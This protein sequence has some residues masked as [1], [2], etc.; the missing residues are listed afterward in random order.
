MNHMGKNDALKDR[1]NNDLDIFLVPLLIILSIIFILIPPFNQ[2]FLRVMLALPLLLF[3]PGYM[4]LA[5]MFPKR[6]ELSALQRFTLSIGLS[7]A[8]TVFDGFGLNYTQWGFRPNSIT[9]SLSIIIG[10]LLWITFRQRRK[11]GKESY[12]FSL[13]DIGSFIKIL[14]TRE[15]E[16]G[17]EY[18]PALEKVL[19]KTM[20]IAILIV[21]A[22]VIYA[23]W[24]YEPQKFTSLY[25]LGQNGK[26]ENYLSDIRVGEPATILV[27]VEN[28]EY[29][30]INYTLLVKLGGITLTKE[31]IHLKH[32]DKWLNNVTF[33]PQMTSTI[34]FAGANRS[35]LEFQLL[36][37]DVPY[38]SVHL[39]VNTSLDL[40]TFAQLP[41]I[42]NGDM[43]SNESW[44]FS[45]SSPNIT[46]G[47]NNSTIFPSIVHEINFISQGQGSYGRISQDIILN[48]SARGVLSFDIKNSWTNIS[49][50]T[51]KQV[52][53]DEEVIWESNIGANKNN[54]EHVEVPVFL[55]GNGTFSL[56][57]LGRETSEDNVT[58]WIDNIELRPY[59]PA[60]N[61]QAIK[62]SSK[63]YTFNFDIRGE[64]R[65]LENNMKIDGFD[66]PGFEYD[67]N[68][69]TSY[70]DFAFNITQENGSSVLLIGIGDST[71]STRVNSSEI[72]LMGERFKIL[73]RDKSTDLTNVTSMNLSKIIEIPSTRNITL[74]ETWTFGRDYS[75]SVS[76]INLKGD[77]A[78]INFRKGGIILESKLMGNGGTYEYKKTAGKNQ[79]LVFRTKVESIAGDHVN[80][81]NMELYSDE[82]IELQMNSSYGDFQVTNIS[83][84]ELVFKNRYPIELN[85][86][87]VIFKD[88]FGLKRSGDMVYPYTSNA[89]IRGTPYSMNAGTWINISAFN[90]PGFYLENDLSYETMRIYFTGN[91][92]VKEGDATYESRVHSGKLS[93][94]GNSYELI[95]PER[96]GYISNVKTESQLNFRE[97]ETK[98]FDSYNFNFK[99]INNN[100]I[101]LW[102]RKVIT[103]DQQGLLKKAI[104]F[105]KSIYPDINYFVLTGKDNFLTKSNILGVGDSFE[106]WEEF[107]VDRDHKKIA[108]RFESINNSNF[109]N[110]SVNLNVRYYDVPFEIFPG[111]MYGDF[112]VYSISSNSIVLKNTRPLLF[113][114]GKEVPLLG[115][116]MKIR[117]ST[118]E[119]LAYPE[120]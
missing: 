108:G 41:E 114:R 95:Q 10:L 9:I 82:I 52:L 89:R 92:Y 70:E 104:D 38:S 17:P 45:A 88:R 23:K 18:D 65:R 6:G 115:G 80:F 96:P 86:S 60:G 28:Y 43:E 73:G 68:N 58:V 54:W 67:I 29:A 33:I 103:K 24:T 106:Y 30:P 5:A 74:G 40:V 100:S 32:E 7:I 79:V 39:W 1:I 113:E 8:I 72:N 62:P 15:T 20:I 91:G 16:T 63:S 26:A 105:N 51:F 56:G 78:M 97:N 35:K 22:V 3:L 93:F 111:K 21:F 61:V 31:D 66:F 77:S 84:Y 119:F 4:F 71:Y 116:V 11:Y 64:P 112:E 27:G 14:K 13:E 53:L 118:S 36:K 44:A 50:Y 37:N 81:S 12:R 102:I 110:I 75:L 99:K 34:A 120:K 94:L 47:Y 87:T 85:D 109:S 19:I 76:L 101:Q 98:S 69:N 25:L 55:S 2:T 42:I 59:D 107:K 49:N 46:A 83:P 57:A 90:Y 117:T 48:G